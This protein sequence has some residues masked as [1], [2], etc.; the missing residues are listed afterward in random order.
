[1]IELVVF[2]MAGT[3]VHD[4]DAVNA[5][6]RAALTAVGVEVDPAVVN[7]VMGLPKPEA[8]RILL[9][10]FRAF[11]G[12]GRGRRHPRR[13]RA[14]DVCTTTRPI[15]PC[16]RCPGPPPRLPPF[17]GQGIKVALNTGFSRPIA[18][19]LLG[20]LGWRVPAVID[21]DVTS[22]EVPRG[23]PHPDMIQHLMARLGIQRRRPGGQGRR[24]EGGPGGRRPT[25]AAAWS[26]ALPAAV[27]RAS[28]C[29]PARIRISWKPS[30]RFLNSFSIQAGPSS[31]TILSVKQSSHGCLAFSVRAAHAA[32]RSKRRITAYSAA[33][34]ARLGSANQ[35]CPRA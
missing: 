30:P 32:Q 6:F 10:A 33:L 1:M 2:D 16:A 27:S 26:S 3:T 22:D 28:N 24:H 31:E 17:A 12:R 5:S 19:V 7:T 18:D 20:R 15:R 11:R 13:F 34:R 23:R 9:A 29:R 4:G 21:A 25:P 14:A 8:I 35:S